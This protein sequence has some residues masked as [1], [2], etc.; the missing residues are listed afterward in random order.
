MSA[1]SPE[2]LSRP[3]D[4]PIT[5]DAVPATV[6]LPPERLEDILVYDPEAIAAF[7]KR[8]PLQIFFR[9]ISIVWIALGYVLG[10]LWDKITG[11]K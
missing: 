11:R 1:A 9:L 2:L 7:Y 4:R 10:L 5:V 8:R 3:S 6:S